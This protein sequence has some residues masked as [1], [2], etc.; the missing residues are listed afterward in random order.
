MPIRAFIHEQAEAVDRVFRT[1]PY[2]VEGL[3]GLRN[4]DALW[5]VGSGTSKN[6]LIGV[7]PLFERLLSVPVHIEGPIGFRANE[8]ARSERGAAIVLSQSGASVTSIEALRTAQERGLATLAL[9]AEA[10]SRFAA[11]AANLRIMP[12]GPEPVGPKTKGYTCSLAELIGIAHAM[13]EKPLPAAPDSAAFVALVGNAEAAMGPLI[14][15]DLRQILVMGQGRHYGTAL[16]GSLKVAEMAGIASSGLDTEEALH[17]RFH[18]LAA[19]D[20]ALFVATDAVQMEADLAAAKAL[21]GLDIQARVLGP[22]GGAPDSEFVLPLPWPETA[23][24]EM[25]LIW[26]VVPFQWL[27]VLLAEKRGMRPEAMRYPDLSKRL[28][29][30]TGPEQ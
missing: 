13:A 4:P 1:L 14:S 8:R 12:V 20:L 11:A 19:G 15:K 16:E 29:I 30:K 28:S 23:V 3:A 9:T 10:D 25:D 7:A 22:V 27:A 21:A 2:A 6:A 18:A 5:L 17:G 26:A 24:A